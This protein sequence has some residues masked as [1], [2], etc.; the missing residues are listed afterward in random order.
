MSHLAP[1][2]LGRSIVVGPGAPVPDR[3]ANA[4]RI[5]IDPELVTDQKRLAPVVD[6]LQRRYIERVPTVIELDPS[7]RLDPEETT[8]LAPY[9]LGGE[10]TFLHERLVKAIWHNSYDGRSDDL[11]WWWATKAAS[12]PGVTVGGPADV[13]L[14]GSTPAWVDGGPRQPLSLEHAVVHHESVELGRMSTA[15]GVT[16]P[17]AA[18]AR[19]QLAAVS[20]L[21]GPARII[22]PAG[23]GKTR[24]LVSR[25]RHL[26]DD[27]GIE[28]ELITALAYNNR[29]AEEMRSRL[30]SEWSRR[31]RTIHSLGLEIVRDARPGVEVAGDG[32][33]RARLQ[34]IAPALPR[35]NTDVIA[36]FIDALSDVQIGLRHPDEVE[37]ATDDVPGF[38]GVF[39]RYRERLLADKRVDYGEMIYGAIEALCRDAA[40]RRRWQH[41]CRHLLVDEFQDLTPGYLLLIRLLASPG[42]NVFGVGD[43]DQVIYG[44]QGA[45]PRFLIDY[46]EL[47][48]GA[49]AHA[50]EVNYRCPRDVVE[51][52]VTLLSY[53]DERVPK[54]IR[55]ASEL[56][57]LDVV[58]APDAEV[59][60]RAA[61]WSRS[62]LDDGAQTADLAVLARVNSA[63]MPVYAA[64]VL[65][66]IPVRSELTPDLLNRSV[67]RATFAWWRMALDPE[68]IRRDDLFEAVRRPARGLVRAAA[69][70]IGNRRGPFSVD[71]LAAMADRFEDKQ[72]VRWEEFCDDIVAAS[73][74]T[75]STT[76]LLDFLVNTVG[77]RG[78][79]EALDSGR[80]RIGAAHHGDDL[81]AL[82][83]VAPL[84][85]VP[86]KFEGWLRE[87]LAT[88]GRPD[89]VLLS[90]VHR[91]KGL[92]WD[93]VLVFGA[94]SGVTPHRL[95]D[96][97]EE[98]RRVFH[99]AITRGI[100]SV[101][102]LA[103]RSRPS[104]FLEEL[105]AP[106]SPRAK[107][108]K[109]PQPKTPARSGGLIVRE[110]DEITVTGG[111]R[112]K[113]M[114][115][116]PKGVTL[117]L[118][119]GAKLEVAWG[120]RVRRGPESGP[121]LQGSPTS[122][123][124]TGDLVERLR[125]WR[126][127]KARELGVPAYVIFNDRTLDDL[128][129]SRPT[130]E[131]ALLR[132]HG[133]GTAK[134][135][136]FG[137]DLLAVIAAAE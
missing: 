128:V 13:L 81:I 37:E 127:D 1:A 73:S 31:V 126:L 93:H 100:R 120:E 54:V 109:R 23:S 118:G 77:L 38:A 51:S 131:A 58:L 28:P 88:P 25:L 79:A 92:E 123:A 59:A 75:A 46:A 135:E 80:S 33:V 53:N 29:A 85:P 15:A 19:D 104:P 63:L 67:L 90:S 108:P 84:C 3:W 137:D 91:V 41:T 83:R 22:A 78:S 2:Q 130:D 35:P 99:V 86:A 71:D 61:D 129:E 106:A 65:A 94:D 62:L 136:S 17:G 7:V 124:G 125:A 74:A 40:L 82:I 134:L 11:K 87:I 112:G 110:G 20:H 121:L 113:V 21:A 132:V 24:V 95:S 97:I 96:D 26:I 27:R 68:H 34:Q 49:G 105:T 4:P 39:E 36:P 89:G 48:P 103:D 133:I 44:Y 60:T 10:F 70:A 76:G 107:E 57:G 64:F 30:P 6:D 66:G 47:F 102:L 18:L 119:T 69:A 45:D 9:E 12:L 117:E 5:V 16:E 111:Y 122:A 55:A 32:E 50:L 8:E 116:H 115:V 72:A 14:D 56:R 98:E 43:D 114:A 42:L 52:S 101:T